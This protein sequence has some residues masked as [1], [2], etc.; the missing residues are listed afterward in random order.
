MNRKQLQLLQAKRRQR[1][2]ASCR[3]QLEQREQD[4]ARQRVEQQQQKE[5]RQ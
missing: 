2:V 1:T 5:P 4:R 3:R